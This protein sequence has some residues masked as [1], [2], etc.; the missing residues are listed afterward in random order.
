MGTGEML[1]TAGWAWIVFIASFYGI[2]WT[3]IGFIG[4][5]IVINAAWWLYRE[6]ITAVP[7]PGSIQ[8]Y[9][10]EARM[11]SLGTSYFI[12]YAPVYGAFMWLELLVAQGLF[13]LLFPA[14][15]TEIWPYFVIIPVIILNLLGHQITG[16]V[17]AALVVVTLVGD[18][19]LA[20]VIWWLV[21]DGD[22]WSA[23]W[24]SPSPVDWLTFFTVAGLWLGIM[25]GILEVQQVLVDEWRKFTS[26]RDVGLLSAAWQLWGRQIP[27]ALAVLAAPRWPPSSSCRCRP[28]RSSRR[29]SV[30][31]RSSTSRCS[32]CWWRRTRP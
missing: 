29:S 19:L 14:V 10:R 4:G 13:S 8:S 27:L 9:G 25:A 5:A 3:I 28:S 31:I 2:K 22:F 6:M 23:N 16:K 24:E 30:R 26:S 32:Q 20:I 17:Q 11:F 1:F 15:P 7:E 21:V 18:V 12:L